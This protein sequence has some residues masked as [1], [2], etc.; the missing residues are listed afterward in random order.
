MM[1]RLNKR[2][3][4]KELICHRNQTEEVKQRGEGED[5]VTSTVI[6]PLKKLVK[7]R[8]I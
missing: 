8:H 6:T 5:I 3:E 2:S 4:C 1:E 7:M